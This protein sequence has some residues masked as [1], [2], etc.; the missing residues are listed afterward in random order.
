MTKKSRQSRKAH[1]RHVRHE[2]R[3]AEFQKAQKART[4]TLNAHNRTRL[5]TQMVKHGA[6]EMG[7]GELFKQAEIIWHL[8][9]GVAVSEECIEM[10]EFMSNAARNARRAIDVLDRIDN[11]DDPDLLT[12]LKKYVEDTCQSIKEVDDRLKK[13]ESSLSALFPEVPDEAENQASWRNLIG[14]RDVI[15]H[16]LLSIDDRRIY[17]EAK[18]DFGLLHEL[19]RNVYFVPTVT[20]FKGGEG[21]SV[22]LKP[23]VIARLRPVGEEGRKIRIGESFTF[24]CDDTE[25]DSCHSELGV[26]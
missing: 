21:F 7:M 11:I 18:R 6:T 26:P 14:R 24:V 23:E 13:H 22:L 5:I 20:H 8:E 3:K 9:E 19:L 16:R 12:A 25:Q 17:D 4:Y 10:E 1:E 15:A 2:R